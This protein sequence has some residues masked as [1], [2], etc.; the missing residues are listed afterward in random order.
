MR[1][2]SDTIIKSR[3]EA[4]RKNVTLAIL[5]NHI[6][7][8]YLDLHDKVSQ[9]GLFFF[10][11]PVLVN[12]MGAIPEKTIVDIARYAAEKA[13]KD[14]VVSMNGNY[15]TGAQPS[16]LDEWLA[17]SDFQLSRK[18]DGNKHICTIL[19]FMGKNWSVCIEKILSP[20]FKELVKGNP[21]IMSTDNAVALQLELKD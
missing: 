12:L 17:I 11:K 9:A 10:P 7:K 1:I 8:D 3:R 20:K 14:L 13:E 15:R 6:F 19:S 2:D 5:G 16:R 18:K 21:R 4:E